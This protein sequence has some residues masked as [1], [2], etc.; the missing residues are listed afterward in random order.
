VDKAPLHFACQHGHADI[1]KL[2]VSGGAHVNAA[3]MVSS[4]LTPYLF[5]TFLFAIHQKVK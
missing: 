3:D 1:V 2:L 5:F 4:S